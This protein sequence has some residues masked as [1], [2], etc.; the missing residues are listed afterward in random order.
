MKILITHDCA[1]PAMDGP[2]HV[3]ANT[4]A[5]LETDT[6]RA[7]VAAG[8]GLY[9]DPKDDPSRAKVSTASEARIEAVRAAIAAARKAAKREPAPTG[10]GTEPPQA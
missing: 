3:D 6:A 10:A 4:L 5:D 1:V 7:V 9:V 8:K 2:A